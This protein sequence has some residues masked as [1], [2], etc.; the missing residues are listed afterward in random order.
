[1]S[2]NTEKE[3][4]E[5]VEE[6]IFSQLKFAVSGNESTGDKENTEETDP[7]ET[8][9]NLIYESETSE[10]SFN[11]R[12]ALT[13]REDHPTETELTVQTERTNKKSLRQILGN[14]FKPD[15]HYNKPVIA[16]LILAILFLLFVFVPSGGSDENE[17]AENTVKAEK[18][19]SSA[20]DDLTGVS[21][22]SVSDVNRNSNSSEEP[23]LG[24]NTNS[25][26]AGMQPNFDANTNSMSNS[27]VQ[28]GYNQPITTTTT[29][30]VTT[31]EPQ[32]S[33]QSSSPQTTSRSVTTVT[34][35]QMSEDFTVDFGDGEQSNNS[36]Q[37][38]RTVVNTVPVQTDVPVNQ[39][40]VMPGT[41]I[42]LI[43][44]EPFRSGIETKV[45]A[46]GMNNVRS[47]DGKT[48]IPANSVFEFTF[49]PEEVSGRVL[50]R[51]IVRVYLPDGTIGEVTGIVKGSDGFAGLTG[52]LTKQNGK[53][54]S[55]KILSGIARVTAGRIGEFGSV[56]QEV[57]QEIQ[58]SGVND[59]DANI[60]RSNRV[61]EIMKGTKF[62]LYVGTPE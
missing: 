51:N 18:L 12:E 43:L 56:G 17:V 55:G 22:G 58:E 46:I 3:Q 21:P 7:S 27:A 26:T 35:R 41:K 9:E 20:S 2:Q 40:R 48:I 28:P 14:I 29:N 44:S 30:T 19:P 61:V 11:S 45:Q 8:G 60:Y 31:V 53:G 49:R 59:R 42:Q 6:D 33:P 5:E 34:R 16:G 39:L 4:P 50:A 32:T 54:I 25:N 10:N 23:I 13:N 57:E 15:G 1:M 62:F 47:S 37:N 52:K 36:Y 38:N 24:G